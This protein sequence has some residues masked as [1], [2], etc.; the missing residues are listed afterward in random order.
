MGWWFFGVCFVGFF[1]VAY[2][3]RYLILG[4]VFLRNKVYLIRE[5]FFHRGNDLLFW[6]VDLVV[7]QG[8]HCV[9]IK[10]CV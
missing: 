4:W 1:L 7:S 2:L 5:N 3:F 10:A 8:L 9:G 6:R